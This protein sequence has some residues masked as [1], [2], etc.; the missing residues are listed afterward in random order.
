[1]KQLFVVAVVLLSFIVVLAQ[2]SPPLDPQLI[3]QQTF[4]FGGINDGVYSS[5][6]TEDGFVLSGG[7][8]V[9]VNQNVIVSFAHIRKISPTGQILWEYTSPQDSTHSYASQTLAPAPDGSVFWSMDQQIGL[10]TIPYVYKFNQSGDVVWQKQLGDLA[11]QNVPNGITADS[12]HLICAIGTSPVTVLVLDMDGNEALPAWQ[13]PVERVFGVAIHDSQLYFSG[14]NPGGININYH[15]EVFKTDLS[16]NIVWQDTL[17]GAFGPHLTFDCD[18]YLYVS[19]S[20]LN[21]QLGWQ[22]IKYDPATGEHIWERTWNGDWNDPVN[23]ADYVNTMVGHCEG[24]VIVGGTLVK[25]GN[26]PNA[27]EGGIVAYTSDGDVMFKFRHNSHPGWYVSSLRSVLLDN[28]HKLVTFGYSFLDPPNTP[29]ELYFA[30]WDGVVTAVEDPK[31]PSFP[32]TYA[33]LQN[34][35]NPFNPTTTISYELPDMAYV[36]LTVYD[37]LGNK[38]AELIAGE[39]PAGRHEIVF[40]AHSLASGIYFYTLQ[41]K[42][43]VETRKMMVLK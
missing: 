41:S 19:G 16:G 34:Y 11:S 15:G 36:N 12:Q 21:T 2:Q 25:E 10:A 29:A 22:T 23:I 20:M 3:E 5:L 26:D 30:K 31:D 39:Q 37:A 8:A 35:P 38:V 32:T 40:N 6:N 33:L 43:F 4:T 42:T 14:I 7:Q 9:L 13:L 27:V 1:M 28:Q 17:M 18:G 24:G